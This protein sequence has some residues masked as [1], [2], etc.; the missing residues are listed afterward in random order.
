MIV[1]GIVNTAHP[2]ELSRRHCP[3]CGNTSTALHHRRRENS[4]ASTS[5]WTA[6]IFFMIN[7]GIKAKF[8]A[9]RLPKCPTGIRG[10]DE[11]TG[12]GLPRGRTSLVCGGAGCGKTLFA[13]EFLVRGAVQFNEPG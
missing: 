13:A 5:D 8:P 11:I 3:L 6:V 4:I 9:R 7:N 1:C 12:G 10:L 2:C